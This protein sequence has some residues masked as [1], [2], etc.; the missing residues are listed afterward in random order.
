MQRGEHEVAGEASL[1]RGHGGF[2]IADLSHQDD[3]GVLPQDRAQRLGEGESL[4]LAYLNLGDPRDI[5][6]HRVLDSD[7]VHRPG[8]E[9]VQRGI[10]GGGLATP[11]RTGNQDHALAMS[12]QALEQVEL[13]GREPD[14][15]Q[16]GPQVGLV[17]DSDHDPLAPTC[18][19]NGR[20][21]EGDVLP[22]HP[23]ASCPAPAEPGSIEEVRTGR[24][25]R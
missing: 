9:L 14:V 22:V 15:C 24:E 19:W 1:N 21:S 12:Q 16:P 4:R 10:Q 3:V 7:D 2:E 8:L 17:K 11:G 13:G 5:V 25:F 20:D 6:F 23:G 18:Y